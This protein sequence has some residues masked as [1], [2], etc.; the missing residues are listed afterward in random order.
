MRWLILV[1][2]VPGLGAVAAETSPKVKAQSVE[3]I[4]V[5]SAFFMVEIVPQL[6]REG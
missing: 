5:M 4:K 3:A 6:L 1:Q 2:V